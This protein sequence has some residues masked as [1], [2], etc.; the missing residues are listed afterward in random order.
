MKIT[1]GKVIGLTSMF[2]SVSTLLILLFEIHLTRR[3]QYASVL[4]YLNIG[5][6]GMYTDNYKFRIKNDGLGPGFITEVKIIQNGIQHN[7]DPFMFLKRL[8]LPYSDSLKYTYT[9]INPGQI[10]G[11]GDFIDLLTAL[12][13]RTGDSLIKIFSDP[14]VLVE[15]KYKSIYDEVWKINNDMMIPIKIK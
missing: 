12:D 13:R 7:E 3:Q 10:I 15:I 8:N 6:Y 5:N 11:P 9:N 4:P 2:V 1:S 14:N